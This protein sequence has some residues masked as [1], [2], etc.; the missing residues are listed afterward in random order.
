M[1]SLAPTPSRP[2]FHP[3]LP[4]NEKKAVPRI[5]ARTAIR[6]AEAIRNWLR[7]LGHWRQERRVAV[8]LDA[9]DD[10]MLK[11]LGIRRSDIPFIAH[12]GITD[13]RC[14]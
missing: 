3:P 6:A 8:S 13:P 11:D 10:A 2:I 9:L 4:R 7:A 5:I 12:T 1:T 14:M